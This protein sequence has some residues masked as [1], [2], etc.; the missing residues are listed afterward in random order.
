M[1]IS[2]AT[3]TDQE[4]LLERIS[5]ARTYLTAKVPFLGFLS[6]KMRPRIATE[7]EQCKTAGVGPDGTLIL[8]FEFVSKQT[9]PELRGLLAH[10]VLHPALHFFQRKGSKDHS[11]FNAAHDYAINQI[12]HDFVAGRLSDN[13]KL[14]EN[15]LLDAKYS[16]MSAEEIYESFPDTKKLALLGGKSG[17]GGDCRPDISS[18]GEGRA[19]GQGDESA[20]D[21]IKR[22]WQIAVVA[23]AQVHEQQKGRGSLPGGLKILIE[24]MLNPKH[25]WT[26]ILARWL[27]ENAGKPD[28]TYQRPSRRSESAGEIL[29]GRRRKSFPD[30]TILWDTSG[31]MHGEEGKIFPEVA[32]MCEELD[33]TI[34]LIIIDAAIHA[35]LT[36]VK[37]AQT[38]AEA[39]KG[40]GASD[41]CPAFD[42]LD[43]E[44]NDSVVLAFTDGA[45]GVPPTMPESLKGVVWVLTQHASAPTTKYGD[46]LRLDPDKNGKWE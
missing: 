5:A 43:E 42:R 36:D 45:I 14:P 6:L 27:G 44:K 40:G 18:G 4:T 2:Q 12:I 37:D 15:G 3:Q 22:D 8:N 28:M 38:I 20:M 32:H 33:L 16:G 41:F 17:L 9:D 26:D 29:I 39:V 11:A 25:H 30:V 7:Q 1:S 35:D 21:R 34:R 46:V 31:S 24:N 10:E 19:A 13:I 23:A